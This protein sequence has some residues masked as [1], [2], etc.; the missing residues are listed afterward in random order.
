MLVREQT[1]DRYNS[2]GY[3]TVSLLIL[4]ELEIWCEPEKVGFVVSIGA[5]DIYPQPRG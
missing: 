4:F 1:A 5:S 3:V 2:N